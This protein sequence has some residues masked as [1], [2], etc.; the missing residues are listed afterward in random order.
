[1]IQVESKTEQLEGAPNNRSRWLIL[2]FLVLWLCSLVILV[3]V[4]LLVDINWT[5]PKVEAGLGQTLHRKIK[6]G[7]LRWHLG[8]NGLMILTRS[9]SISELDGEPFLNARGSNIGLEFV[10]LLAGKIKIKHLQIDHPEIYAVKLKAG[11]WNFEDLFDAK[12]TVSFVQIDSG[13]IHIMDAT[14]QA[15]DKETF[16]L[17]DV[18]VKFNW[19]RKGRHLPLFLSCSIVD[20]PAAKTTLKAGITAESKAADKYSAQNPAYLEVEG[21]STTKDKQLL[22]TIYDVNLKLADMPSSS[23]TRLLS[24]IMDDPKVKQSF[25]P[26]PKLAKLRG[27]LSVNAKIKGSIASGFGADVKTELKNVVLVGPTI[28]KMKTKSVTGAGDINVTNDLIAWNNLAF[29]LGGMELKTRGDLKNWQRKDSSYVIGMSSKAVD[30]ASVSS[31]IEFS[32]LDKKGQEEED[33]ILRIFKTISMSGKAFFDVTMT[34]DREKAKLMTQLEAEGLPVSRLVDEIAPELAPLFIVSGV[35]R[36]AVVKGHFASSG[37]RR[38]SIDKGII[39]VPDSSI[40]LDG[41]V[42]L[43]KDAVDIKFE[44]EDFPLKKAWDNALKDERTRKTIASTLIDTNPRSIVVAGYVKASG[45]IVRTKKNTTISIVAQVHDGAIAYNDNTL[46]TTNINGTVTFKNGIVSIDGFKGNIGKGG[47]FKLAGKVFNLLTGSPYC[48]IDF[49][50]TGVNFAH[51]GSVMN[52]FR[53]SF[54][55]ITEGHLTGTVKSLV[56]KITGSHNH[57][58]VYFNAAPDDVSYQPPGL[59]RGLKANGGNIIYQN[60][61]VRLENVGILARNNRIVTNLTIYNLLTKAR[62]RDIHVKTDGIELGDIDYYLSSSVMPASLRKSYRDLLSTYKIKNM[63]GKIYGDVVVVPKPDDDLADLEGVIGCYSVGATVSKLNLPLER[64]AGT[65]AASGNELLIQDLTGYVRSTQFEVNGWVKD[66]K[67]ANPNWKTELHANIAPNEFLDLVP[68]LTETISNG[69]LKIYSAGPMALRSKVEGNNQ[70][71]E[72]VFSAHADADDHLRISTPMAVINQPHLQELNLDG[73]ATLDK[74]ALTLHKTNLT[75]GDASLKTQGVWQWSKQDQPV[76]MTVESN[77]PVPAKILL[78]LVDPTFDTKS[79]TGSID[80]QVSLTGPLRHPILTGKVSLDKIT[81]PDFGIFDLT[82]TISTDDKAAS[83]PTSGVTNTPGRLAS[84]ARVDLD[85]LN[86]RKLAID[87]IGG[88]V[89]IEP[90]DEVPG[91]ALPAPPKLGLRGFTAKAAG[92][93]FKLDGS[94]NMGKRSA[95]F[96]NY[97]SKVQTEQLVDKLL[98]APNELTGTMDGEIHLT[99]SGEDYKKILANL[100]G[101]GAIVVQN[102]VVA[103]FGQLQTK[104]TQANLLEQGILGFNFNNLLQSMVPVRTGVY[105]KLSSKFSVYKGVLAIKELRYSGD[106]LR[107]W[108]AG[109]VNLPT[110]KMDVEIAGNIPRVTQSMLGG[111]LGNLSRRIT[112]AKVLNKITF[113]ALESLPALPLI[114]EIA[115]DK[116][117]TFSF[118]VDA[119]AS[120]AKQITHTIERSFKWLPNK[121]AA[122]AHPVPGV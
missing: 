71:N 11:A 25:V 17:N 81:N 26:D 89:Q 66:Y 111:E 32:G 16:D 112:I 59:T 98:N 53:L 46:D 83:D 45:N 57:P 99:S 15:V 42:D 52:V 120:D 1:V 91:S 33:Q 39:T 84:V 56:I 40:K 4:G 22:D 14:P 43:L 70:R 75:L 62:L 31:A 119:P 35:G 6:L 110:D 64:L 7:A 63:H 79:I 12:T 36:D 85:R 18:N 20:N 118:K 68:A 109:V 76:T 29:K 67:T 27:S 113:G 117:R 19:P 23:L 58:D 41:E 80:G 105:K 78:E 50:G 8:L 2:R 92:G 5:R 24:I 106:D 103:R 100:E 90:G 102:G 21:L 28:G 47:Y 51:L 3:A 107:M 108:G 48:S 101:T 93:Q 61:T 49:A 96:N 44:L 121:Q 97:F 38:V 10:P 73:S 74:E 104:I 34:G 86:L 30:L 13:K 9:L 116:P 94:I 88:W 87:D 72:V 77:K 54:P 69:K 65:F 95:T 115:S 37:G 114:G 122:T 60:D 82:G 55:A